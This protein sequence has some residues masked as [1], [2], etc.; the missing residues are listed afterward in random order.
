ML[1]ISTRSIAEADSAVRDYTAKLQGLDPAARINV[2]SFQ[3][4][5]PVDSP[6]EVRIVGPELSQL[7]RL[8]DQLGALYTPLALL[9]VLQIGLFVIA[10]LRNRV[11]P[12]MLLS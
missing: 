5:V 2:T 10:S 8:G 1:L 9:L 4:G 12:L 6:V 7:R 3:Q 11:M